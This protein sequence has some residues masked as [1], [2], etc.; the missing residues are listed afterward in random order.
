MIKAQQLELHLMDMTEAK[1]ANSSTG[2]VSQGTVFR[3][4]S[5]M[6]RWLR[7]A[8]YTVFSISGQAAAALLNRLYYEKGGT[9]KWVGSLVQVVG[10]PILLPYF[11]ISQRRKVITPNISTA[12][13]ETKPSSLLSVVCV[14]VFLGLLMA[15]NAYLYSVG[16]QYLPV[17]TV[18]LITASQLAFNAFFSYFLNSQ[19][20]T[21]FIINSLVLLTMSSVLLVA[22]N[23]S[24]RPPG[25]SNG[26][27]VLGFICTIFAAATNGLLLASQQLA[28]RKVLKMQSFK[29]VM[30]LVIYGSLVASIATTIGFLASGEWK[31]LKREM[32][33]Y[34]LGSTSYVMT[35]VWTAVACQVFIFCC[36]ALVF[37]L[38]ALF[39]NA[40][41][42]FGLPIVPI[43]AMIVF[44][45]QMSCIKGISM[46]LAIWGFLSYVYQQYLDDRES[47]DKNKK[48]S[49]VSEA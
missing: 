31:G 9:S 34:A 3:P 10:F 33:G 45:D 14:Y 17:S 49:E 42:A 19:K 12:A 35:L 22:N 27:Y 6:I 21:P 16:F 23:S 43:A 26:K 40:I 8:F 39:S 18:A 29:V 30:D 4:K 28:F 13:V 1:G 32:E 41:A 47:N 11:F 38:S 2:T 36:A 15:V 5:Y 46:V 37:E 48:G 44:H 7:I 24:E 20:F 25:V